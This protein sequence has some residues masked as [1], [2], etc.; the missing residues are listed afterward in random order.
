MVFADV[1]NDQVSK[2]MRAI[3]TKLKVARCTPH[4]LRRTHGTLI[5]GLGFGRDGMNRV[6]NH[7]EGGI[8]D[9]YDRHAYAAEN[10]KIMEAVASR[11]MHLI[12][13]SPTNVIRLKQ[14]I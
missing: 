12:N 6:Q 4:D 7:K 14:G 8:T 13:G 9:T 1:S 5:T 2:A 11:I 3:C 10:Q